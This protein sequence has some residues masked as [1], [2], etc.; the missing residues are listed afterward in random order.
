M[1]D[2]N[3]VT[4]M[5]KDFGQLAKRISTFTTNGLLSAVVLVAGLGFGRQVLVWW[6]DGA[7]S[8]PGKQSAPFA[9][10]LGDPARMHVL[11]FA[12][13][14]WSLGRQSIGGDKR[15][16]TDALRA[17]CREAVATANPPPQPPGPAQRRLLARLEGDDPLEQQAGKWRL[18]LLDEAFPMIVGVD[19]SRNH[20]ARVVT[21]GLG[22]PVSDGQWTLYALK[23]VDGSGQTPAVL[24]EVPLPPESNVTMSMAIADGGAM[25]AFGGPALPE[26]TKPESW[27][28]FYEKWF[29][30]HGWQSATGWQRT[31]SAWH[32]R[33]TAPRDAPAGSVDVRLAANGHGGLGGLLIV[34]P[35]TA[36]QAATDANP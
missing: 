25:V 23:R 5:P 32:A 11:Q 1:S 4:A 16:A 34:T 31:G 15:A 27:K 20:D 30:A 14:P 2:G 21:W 8:P 3:G 13:Q 24:G 26:A 33:Y 7:S 9:G 12:N 35:K 28:A 36:G 17:I 19:T 29:A 6:A 10:G 22:L 18:Y